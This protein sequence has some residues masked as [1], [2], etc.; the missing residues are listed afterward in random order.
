MSFNERNF[1]RIL[2]LIGI[3][4]HTNQ[5]A[6]Y[7]PEGDVQNHT[8][9]V[10]NHAVRESDDIELILAALCHDLGKINGISVDG[11]SH[12]LYSKEIVEKEGL[13]DKTIWLVSNHIRIKMY[14]DGRMKKLAKANEMSSHPWFADLV[15]LHRWDMMGRNAKTRMKFDRSEIL[16]K[17]NDKDSKTEETRKESE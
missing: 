7:H 3:S 16:Q 10:F 11:K 17:L 9:Q 5:R 2:D 8:L 6:D 12:D 14:L 1:G 13:S 15:K 4:Q